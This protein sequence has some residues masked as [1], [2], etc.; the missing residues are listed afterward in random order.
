MYKE[1]DH[2]FRFHETLL[3]QDNPSKTLKVS[4]WKG[5]PQTCE[6]LYQLGYSDMEKQKEQILA[7]L[8]K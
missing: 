7:L 5:D 1:Y 4:R 6:E 3:N 2:N 8:K